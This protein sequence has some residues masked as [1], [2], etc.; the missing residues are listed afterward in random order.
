MLILSD[1]ALWVNRVARF[2]FRAYD[3]NLDMK[4]GAHVSAAA[5][6]WNAP[7][8][9]AAIGC[10]VLQMFSRPPQG[11]KPS[12]IT[13]EVA[14]KFK[15]AMK[16]F[17]IE[18]AYIHTPYFINLASKEKRIVEGSISV[19]RDELERGSA[20][21]CHAVMFHPGSAKDVG[22]AK[23]VSMVIE[24]LNRIVDG[25]K[26]RCQL[27]IEI[28]AGAGAIMGDSFE[29]IAAFLNGADR[30]KDIGVCFDTQHAFASG[31]DLRTK[32]TVTQTF[33]LFDKLIGLKKLVASHC[34]DS[35]VELGG[36][37][38]RHEHLGKG[39]IGLE[40][41]RSIVNHPKLQH[42]DLIL[43]TPIDD[44]VQEDLRKLKKYRGN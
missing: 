3:G 43:E 23:G 33:D 31:Y 32:E 38:D 25:Y 35:K 39:Y 36:H 28:S 7:K 10:E 13:D 19:I 22:Q 15:S 27:L 26:G 44:G 5:G 1:T 29:E 14:Q 24:G 17:G 8:N 30:G 18:R 40:G 42:L 11:G 20:L 41:F 2:S 16:E 6:L 34:N 9:A 12:P 37:K 21:G 4:F